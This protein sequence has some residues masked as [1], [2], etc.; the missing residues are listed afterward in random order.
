VN[1]I[2]VPAAIMLLFAVAA[3]R[4]QTARPA[5]TE[6]SVSQL[7]AQLGDPDRQVREQASK[8]LWS[9]GKTAGPA[10]RAAAESDDPEVARR[11][12]ILLRD[13]TYGLTPDAPREIFD[14]VE[15]YRKGDDAQK[16][17]AIWNLGSQ[18]IPGLR[19]LLMLRQE[20]RDPDLR[21]VIAQVLAPHEHDVAVWM[22][23]DG[24]ADNVEQILRQTALDS[25]GA[26]QDYAAL[27]L[28]T[29]QAQ[30]TLAK[31]K[32]EPPTR[33]N[34]P[35]MLALARAAG[36]PAAARMAAEQSGSPE[37]LDA[38]LVE[39]G[40]F[41]TLAARLQT[42]PQRL[43][44]QQRLGFS[45]A[46]CRL[47]GDDAGFA[48]AARQLSDL[49]SQSPE[50]Y[51]VCATAL[52]LNGLADEGESI[53]LKHK[54]YTQASYFLGSRLKFAQA[55]EL[56]KLARQTRLDEA[57]EVSAHAVGALHFTGQTEA[58]KQATKEL[59]D[60]NRLR[61]DY[62]TWEVLID[63]AEQL[64]MTAEADEYLATALSKTTRQD[65]IVSLLEH[66]GF[67]DGD[68][69]QWWQFLRSREASQSPVQSLR[70]LRSL[71][72]HTIAASELTDLAETA[73]RYTADLPVTER[74]GWQ[75]SVARML[76]ANGRG[77]L[78]GQ[79]FDQL[80]ADSSDA[81]VLLAAADFE[82]ARGN[83]SVATARYQRAWEH[84]RTRAA[85]LFL[86]GWALSHAEPDKQHEAADLMKRAHDLP[87]GSESERWALFESLLAHKLS[88]DAD[89]ELGL[90]LT[91]TPLMSYERTNALRQTGQE[92][93][94]RSDYL[95]AA[96]LWDRALLV[97]LTG[98]ISFR[99]PWANVY[100][101]ALIHKWRALGLIKAGQIPE[102]IKQA[103]MTLD[104][105]PADAD[106]LIE[107]ANALDKAG[108]GTE[109]DELFARHTAVYRKLIAD[110]PASGP[111]HNQLAWAQV[112]C[113]R[114]LDDALKNARRAVELEPTSTASLD[115]LAE[116]YFARG[117]AAGAITQMKRCVELE[118][119]VARHRRQLARFEAELHPTTRP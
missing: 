99:E 61:N 101:P 68:A 91:V 47:A 69:A 33:R 100:V 83:W 21:Q 95:T 37:L 58:A 55:I 29:G 87:L 116:V 3:C 94:D 16:R 45:C 67:G 36:D 12:K 110:Y 75:A 57:L 84:D 24:Q 65:P 56:P 64:Q 42:N 70:R 66:G 31:L 113:R 63:D 43:G 78:A 88:D 111:G 106:A 22:L 92:A 73:R 41:K 44:P 28:S 6:P 49:A 40:D 112:M 76:A 9:R 86:Y 109:T 54:D 32:S 27:L 46:Y 25:P 15:Q 115:T 118:P 8:E 97:N 19:V 90:I 2:I 102:A 105:V 26:A 82:A 77:D 117:D 85:A 81:R 60:E 30:A 5:T 93:A 35:L 119:A 20:E 1:R 107:F 48:N 89:K 38:V 59:A 80:A 74:Q 50:E 96:G 108:H 17:T 13:F 62:P 18:G 53:L 52:M 10:I 51:S 34:A 72:D 23:A 7:I 104:E 103:S 79:W 98:N 114:E 4:G 11:A 39:Q 71:Y 14:L